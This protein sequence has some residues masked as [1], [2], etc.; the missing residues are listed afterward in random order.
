MEVRFWKIARLGAVD[1][2]PEV[3]PPNWQIALDKRKC[4][5]ISFHSA[6]RTRYWLEMG[7]AEMSARS[8]RS[9]L[10]PR[11]DFGTGLQSHVSEERLSGSQSSQPQHV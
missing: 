9:T 8:P 11:G 3:M 2:K 1:G 4:L 5:P 7:F 10:P 6:T